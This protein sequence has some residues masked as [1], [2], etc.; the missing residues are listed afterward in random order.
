MAEATEQ[1]QQPDI[2]Q[3]WREWLTQSERQ[4][5]AF[6]N[7]MMGTE[8]FART[9]G[10]YM[11]VYATFQ[12]LLAQAMERYL[13]FVNVPS[14]TDITALAETLQTIETRL[15]RIEETLLIAAEA[16]DGGTRREPAIEPARTRRPAGFPA[17]EPAAEEPAAV[18]EELRR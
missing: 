3:L 2:A 4:L 18:P 16:V 17:P 9:M 10:T 8:G 15:A 6:F 13:A 1:Q 11:E 7:E 14:R 5:N 12:R